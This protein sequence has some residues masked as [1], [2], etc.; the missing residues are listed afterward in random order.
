MTKK[1]AVNATSGAQITLYTDDTLTLAF[2]G[3]VESTT[4]TLAEFVSIDSLYEIAT[5]SDDGSERIKASHA[6]AR[7]VT[8]I[9]QR[10][11]HS[12][13]ELLTMQLQA[14]RLETARLRS[15]IK[16]SG[17]QPV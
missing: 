6:V 8:R 12:Q 13:I 4:D 17:G 15:L 9:E 1:T 3:M 5:K 14:E 2:E 7:S 16:L 11:L 10:N